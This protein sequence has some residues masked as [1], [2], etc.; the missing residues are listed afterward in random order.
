M[1]DRVPPA[2][3]HDVLREGLSPEWAE[4]AQR[5]RAEPKARPAGYAKLKVALPWESLSFRKQ[6]EGGGNLSQKLACL[7]YGVQSSSQ[8]PSRYA[9]VKNPPWDCLR[10]TE[11]DA[12]VSVLGVEDGASLRPALAAIP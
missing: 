2:R 5:L 7:T 8:I 9:N 1:R 12:E 4:T 10:R 3:V 6:Y 11:W